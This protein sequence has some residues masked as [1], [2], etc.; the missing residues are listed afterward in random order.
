MFVSRY[1]LSQLGEV[2][3]KREGLLGSRFEGG[4]DSVQARLNKCLVELDGLPHTTC[5][6]GVGLKNCSSLVAPTSVRLHS[7]KDSEAQ[8]K[9]LMVGLEA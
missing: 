1:S 8:F 9:V 7:L 3:R 4:V 6:D 5:L 2:S